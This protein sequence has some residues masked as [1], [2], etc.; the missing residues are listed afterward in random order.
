MPQNVM[1]DFRKGYALPYG[2]GGVIATLR[3]KLYK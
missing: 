3:D 2:I 1:V